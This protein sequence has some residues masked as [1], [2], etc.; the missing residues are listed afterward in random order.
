MVDVGTCRKHFYR[1]WPPGV[2]GGVVFWFPVLKTQQRF[3]DHMDLSTALD[4]IKIPR[5]QRKKYVNGIKGDI[6]FFCFPFPLVVY[7][8][9]VHAKG[10]QS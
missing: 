6:L 9:F 1:L 3:L 8:L 7:R 10:L 2:N 4:I 5:S